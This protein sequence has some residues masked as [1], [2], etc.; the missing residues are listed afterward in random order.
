MQEL[1]RRMGSAKTWGIEP[2][3]MLTPAEIK[4]LVPF[5]DESLIVGGF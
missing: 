2:V 5:I 3:S 4:E 1:G